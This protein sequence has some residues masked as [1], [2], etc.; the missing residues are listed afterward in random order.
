MTDI[1]PQP[2]DCDFSEK[3]WENELS[4]YQRYYYRNQEEEQ[5]RRQERKDEMRNWFRKIKKEKY[6]CGECGESH[7]ACIDF[8]H[9]D[10]SDKT[11][12]VANMIRDGYSKEAV[13]EEI[14]KC[15][16]LCA[17]CHRKKHYTNS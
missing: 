10:P 9:T 16:T 3:E 7:P 6:D 2:E 14:E 12:H 4:A 13:L 11:D 15:K 5:K 17:N 8:H 1:I